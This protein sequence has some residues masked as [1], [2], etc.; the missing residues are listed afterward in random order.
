MKG[1]TSGHVLNVKEIFIDC[2]LDALVITVDPI[3]PTCHTNHE[4]CFYR[5]ITETG[6]LE[7]IEPVLEA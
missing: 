7:E 2:D 4:S 6:E 5:K 1:E 3:G